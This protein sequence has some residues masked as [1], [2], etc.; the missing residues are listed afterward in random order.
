MPLR[1]SRFYLFGYQ[2]YYGHI[3]LPQH[4]ARLAAPVRVSHVPVLPSPARNPI[5]PRVP[6]AV[7]F[8]VLS[9]L[10]GRLHHIRESGRYRLRVTRLNWSSLQD[11]VH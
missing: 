3:R 5:L 1:S 10:G 7:H 6:L 9:Q 2:H 11:H 8:V 4:A